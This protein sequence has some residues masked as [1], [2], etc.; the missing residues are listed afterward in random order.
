MKPSGKRS[1]KEQA[2]EVDFLDRQST[3]LRSAGKGGPKQEKK[4][5]LK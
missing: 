3:V 4:G 1:K 5:I 2:E